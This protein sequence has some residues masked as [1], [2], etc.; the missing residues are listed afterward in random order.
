MNYDI[1]IELTD[2]SGSADLLEDDETERVTETEE[3]RREKRTL[4]WANMGQARALTL[5]H[6]YTDA[7]D[8]LT[9]VG[10][11]FPLSHRH[12]SFVHYLCCCY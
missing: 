3:Q 4:Y 12:S 6:R 1:T 8:A 11:I 7:R 10:A 9:K 2:G 5:S